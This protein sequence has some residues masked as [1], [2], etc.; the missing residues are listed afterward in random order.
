MKSPKV[1][2]YRLI[3]VPDHM[4]PVAQ[5]GHAIGPVPFLMF[6]S[7]TPLRKGSM[8]PFDERALQETHLFVDDGYRLMDQLLSS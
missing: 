3:C 6:D 1:D 8:L 4:T 2:D 5:R 7:R